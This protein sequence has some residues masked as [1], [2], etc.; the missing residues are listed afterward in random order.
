MPSQLAI[1][2]I[3]EAGEQPP[4]PS[5]IGQEWFDSLSGQAQA[6]MAEY[7]TTD[8]IELQA[9]VLT[10]NP[11]PGPGDEYVAKALTWEE[12]AAIDG[13]GDWDVVTEKGDPITAYS[14]YVHMQGRGVNHIEDY[15]TH[16]E[17]RAIADGLAAMLGVPV[18][19]FSPEQ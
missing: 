15:K 19:D 9:T 18:N 1:R 8:A 16:E 17:A 10:V 12:A 13:A 14:I 5:A 7:P 11:D 6:I 3:G 4:L 2:L